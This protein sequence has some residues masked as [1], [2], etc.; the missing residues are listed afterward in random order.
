MNRTRRWMGLFILILIFLNGCGPQSTAAPQF[1]ETQ[2][3]NISAT[4][5]AQVIADRF[6]EAWAEEAYGEMYV[7]L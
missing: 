6:L 3:G 4:A 5:E 1:S 2:Q 7:L